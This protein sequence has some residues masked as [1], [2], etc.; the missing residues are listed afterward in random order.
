M[1]FS[2]ASK[3]TPK[4]TELLTKGAVYSGTEGMTIQMGVDYKQKLRYLETDAELKAAACSSSYRNAGVLKEK[5]IETVAI[6]DKVSYCD[7]D[8]AGYELPNNFLAESTAQLI[9]SF[10]SKVSLLRWAGEKLTGDLFDGFYTHLKAKSSISASESVAIVAL[11]VAYDIA[12]SRVIPNT[13]VVKNAAETTTYVEDT[14]YTVDY[15]NGT[16]TA[17]TG[18]AIT[19]GST[20]HLTAYSYAVGATSLGDSAVL[21]NSNIDDK[22]N[23]LISARANNALFK[24]KGVAELFMPSKYYQMI[25]ENRLS[26]NY[27]HD[28]LSQ[29]DGWMWAFG[30]TN[31]VKIVEVPEMVDI[32]DMFIT[33]RKNLVVSLDEKSK[34]TAYKVFFD[35]PNELILNSLFT[36]QGTQ[37]KFEEFAYRL[38]G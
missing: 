24:A 29:G 5:D 31:S 33:F 14:D 16:I 6:E 3:I 34:K 32:D 22:V 38:R 26:S 37:I 17:I 25:L 35:E 10:K 28:T 18:G 30:Y 20:I 23:K 1:D 4:T 9:E 21:T 19:A 12:H 2:G 11:D 8:W 7:K 36:K 13:L 15:E 27:F